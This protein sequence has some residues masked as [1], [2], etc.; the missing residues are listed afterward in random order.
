MSTAYRAKRPEPLAVNDIKVV[1]QGTLDDLDTLTEVEGDD[2]WDDDDQHDDMDR[3]DREDDEGYVKSI[4]ATITGKT[5]SGE[6][7]TIGHMKADLLQVHRAVQNRE[8]LWSVPVKE[9]LL[10]VSAAA[11]NK[12]A[13]GF[14][15]GDL[16]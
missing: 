10:I 9:Q 5:A 2:S 14:R 8:S 3:E 1:F 11:P 15:Q 7:E 6:R 16:R 12:T 13:D 4:Y